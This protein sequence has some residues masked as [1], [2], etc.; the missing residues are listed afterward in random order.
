VTHVTLVEGTFGGTWASDPASAFR[1]MLRRHDVSAVVFEGWTTN[2]DGVP[3]ILAKGRHRDWI[4][5]GYALS[6]FLQLMP[7]EDRN[8]ICHSHG[9]MPVLYACALGPVPVRRVI[10]VCSPVRGDM[11][12][13]ADAAVPHIDRWRHISSS[14]GDVMQRLGELFDG[15]FSLWGVRQWKQ[16]H[17][18]LSIPGI[19]HSKLL[20]DPKFLDLWQTDG[21]LDFLAATEVL[22]V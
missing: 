9:L 22:G 12:A 4:A 10:S 8:I 20:N 7:Y 13:T 21:M 2:I 15:Y 14:R 1:D 18:N 11:Q 16:A 19:G 3:N 6:Y 17:E 5:G